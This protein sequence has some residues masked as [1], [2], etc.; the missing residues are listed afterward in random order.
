MAAERYQKA[1]A[2]RAKVEAKLIRLQKLQRLRNVESRDVV[3]AFVT[4][5]HAESAY[6]CRADY[7]YTLCV[8]RPRPTHAPPIPCPPPPRVARSACMRSYP[9]P[10]PAAAQRPRRVPFPRAVA[11]GA[12]LC[13]CVSVASTG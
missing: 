12:S 2:K 10:P 7:H 11:H 9:L 3:G 13:P 1:M 6:R 4:F 8:A 5:Q